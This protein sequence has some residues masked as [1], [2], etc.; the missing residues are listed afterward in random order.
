MSNLNKGL[1]FKGAIK[2][3][4]HIKVKT[5]DYGIRSKTSYPTSSKSF[6]FK[7][8]NTQLVKKSI[9][10]L[11]RV[12]T[13]T[14]IKSAESSS[15]AE[16]NDLTIGKI[17]QDQQNVKG[18]MN[19]IG[20]YQKSFQTKKQ[21]KKELA[22]QKSKE[23]HAS[24]VIDR[25]KQ[26]PVKEV[27]K[28]KQLIKSKSAKVTSKHAKKVVGKKAGIKLTTGT[29][30]GLKGKAMLLKMVRLATSG[31]KSIATFVAFKFLI[32]V[33]VMGIAL[34]LI[35]S[36]FVAIIGVTASID[37]AIPLAEEV[38][39]TEI[40]VHL[41][42][43]D[44]DW[45]E[46][47]MTNIR[48]DTK[49]VI[50]LIF[51]RGD[52]D[53]DRENNEA[54]LNDV[55]EFH[56]AFHE[57]GLDDVV[58]FLR[59]HT[60]LFTRVDEFIE[61]RGIAFFHFYGTL[62]DPY[63]RSSR[64]Y[65]TSHFGWRSD[66]FE[67][68]ER[69]MHNGIDIAWPGIGGVPV[70]ATINGRVERV[71]YDAGGYGNWV[72]IVNDDDSDHVKETR[73]A[74]LRSTSVAVGQRVWVGDVIGLTGTTGSSTGDHLHYEFRRNGNLLNPYFYFPNESSE[75]RMGGGD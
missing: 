8:Q 12:G 18:Y 33:A 60:I 55:A 61:Y 16:K 11:K 42:E 19:E 66:P 68:G 56:Q 45:N 52:I 24:K 49:D 34:I 58:S 20:N 17:Y 4:D 40:H 2:S 43:L 7:K 5:R 21:R 9:S 23:R 26:V 13:S 67:S 3:T 35:V 30:K 74:H 6:K 75:M 72:M 10:T 51:M 63:D 25:R 15:E 36:I 53:H 54:I 37:P 71:A 65:V 70:R 27:R 64:N 41:T 48:T 50:A 69:L 28:S 39:V 22:T 57:S 46:A 59:E 14:A 62:G 44:L 1:K 38:L 31:V 32:P 29:L 73:Y 47:N